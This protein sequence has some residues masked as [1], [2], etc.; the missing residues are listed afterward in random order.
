VD[1]SSVVGGENRPFILN[2]IVVEAAK[3]EEK[4]FVNVIVVDD[5]EHRI[6]YAMF[7][8]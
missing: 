6:V 8:I 7:Y 3:V 1:T 4:P 2:F 5:P